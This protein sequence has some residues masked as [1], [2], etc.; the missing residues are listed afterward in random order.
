MDCTG[1][2]SGLYALSHI[3]MVEM[4]F[5]IKNVSELQMLYLDPKD[6]KCECIWI[7]GLDS[8]LF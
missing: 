7:L 6:F 1:L 8:G 5:L 4:I 2:L 3:H